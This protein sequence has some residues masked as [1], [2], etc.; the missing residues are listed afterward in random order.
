MSI[1]VTTSGMKAAQKLIDVFGNNIANAGTDGFKRSVVSFGDIFPNDPSSSPKTAVGQGVLV[2]NISRDQSQGSM[3]TTG[4]ATDLAISGSGFFTLN[5]NGNQ[6]YTRSGSFNLD[7]DGYLVDAAGNNVQMEVKPP[8]SPTSIKYDDNL[9]VWNVNPPTQLSGLQ[10]VKIP[11]ALN[12]GPITPTAQ[13]VPLYKTAEDAASSQNPATDS[14][15][16]PLTLTTI[17][18]D[19]KNGSADEVDSV[20]I[21]GTKY[22]Y[23][24][25]D[26]KTQVIALATA[27]NNTTSPANPSFPYNNTNFQAN[28]TNPLP[29]PRST[30]NNPPNSETDGLLQS[31]NVDTT[32]LITA[33]YAGL[34]TP[35]PIGYVAIANFANPAALQPIGNTDFQATGSSG[36]VS[37]SAA[38]VPGAGTLQSGAVETSNVDMTNELVQ[39]IKAQQLYNGNA[40]ALQTQVEVA[41]RVTDKL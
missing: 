20:S 2:S 23:K 7:K 32:G 11:F 37:L 28:L 30:T 18:I 9:G 15:Q 35:Y 33:T 21:N 12:R 14:N 10:S 3:Q 34:Q 24:N 40:R 4:K 5:S 13:A 16:Q 26:M 6:I 36:Q 17:P 27:G 38:G 22:Y 29:E 1:T 31:I 25:S 39:L 8:G 19:Y 41:S